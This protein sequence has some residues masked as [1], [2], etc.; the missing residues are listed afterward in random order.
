MR[1]SL[2]P[3]DRSGGLQGG[4][5]QLL[6]RDTGIMRRR[7]TWFSVNARRQFHRG[8]PIDRYGMELQ[9]RLF[10]FLIQTDFL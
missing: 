8:N 7:I 1:T 5:L 6:E 10:Y 9:N 2:D 3:I 4:L